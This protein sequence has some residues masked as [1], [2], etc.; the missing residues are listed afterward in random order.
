MTP[1][2]IITS[3]IICILMLPII[4]SQSILIVWSLVGFTA[5][6]TV[7]LW[8]HDKQRNEGETSDDIKDILWL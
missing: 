6:I 7:T 3:D 4:P 5:L 2:G 8:M 1:Y